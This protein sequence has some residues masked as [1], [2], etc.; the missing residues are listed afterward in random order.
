MGAEHVSPRESSGIDLAG[1]RELTCVTSD[2]IYYGDP[3]GL[4]PALVENLET[5]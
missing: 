1:V 5:E 4:P 2:Y 3:S